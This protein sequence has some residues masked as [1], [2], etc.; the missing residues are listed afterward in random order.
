MQIGD[1]VMFSGTLTNVGETR[2]TAVILNM[3][4]NHKRNLQFLDVLWPSGNVARMRSEL[5]VKVITDEAR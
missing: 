2:S 4:Y 1:L 3:W 5:F